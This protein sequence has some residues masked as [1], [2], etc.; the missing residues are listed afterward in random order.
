MP[1]GCIYIKQTPYW[2]FIPS[3]HLYTS[4]CLHS[5]FTYHFNNLLCLPA[6][7]L[8][9]VM[10]VFLSAVLYSRAQRHVHTHTHT[11]THPHKHTHAHILTHKHTHVM[12][13]PRHTRAL[14]L[15]HT[16]HS[17][18]HTHAHTHTPFLS[19]TAHMSY[20]APICCSV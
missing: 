3:S 7:L 8:I 17:R 19:V 15:T 5:F 12:H 11:H 18:T 6:T 16:W 14:T 4:V 2:L 20:I 13:I 1:C 9:G 10:S